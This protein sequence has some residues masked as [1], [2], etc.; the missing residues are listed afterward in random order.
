MQMKKLM[1]HPEKFQDL[2]SGVSKFQPSIQ[3]DGST[4]SGLPPPVK[5]GL[6][7]FSA[8]IMPLI[9]VASSAAS[10]N[11][12]ADNKP[13]PPPKD[14]DEEEEEEEEKPEEDELDQ[15]RKKENEEEQKRKKSKQK[16]QLSSQYNWMPINNR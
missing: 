6:A 15:Q 11:L 9:S 8:S 1:R 2:L 5:I 4:F 12:N 14:D 10:A 16:T 13:P 7:A 3:K